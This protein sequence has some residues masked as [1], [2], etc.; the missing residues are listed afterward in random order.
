MTP[1]NPG[2]VVYAATDLHNDG[3]HP[4]FATGETVVRAG[5]RG[6]LV[7]IGHVEETL[8]ELYLVRFEAASGDLGPPIGC[9]PK[10][11]TPATDDPAPKDLHDSSASPKEGC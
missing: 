10:E 9:W 11:L 2:D 5:T 6:V 8:A 1:P 3:S 4:E 7:R